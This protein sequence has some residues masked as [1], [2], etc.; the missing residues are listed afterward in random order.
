MYRNS[1]GLLPYTNASIIP[2]TYTYRVEVLLLVYTFL[3]T[4]VGY[5]NEQTKTKHRNLVI[6]FR[7][8]THGYTG[9]HVL[10]GSVLLRD[11]IYDRVC[12]PFKKNYNN[13][14]HGVRI[15]VIRLNIRYLR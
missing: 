3:H 12:K 4:P 15:Y 1:R 10:P 2:I 8:I 7:P 6:H 13:E 5:Y 9:I 14:T 11:S